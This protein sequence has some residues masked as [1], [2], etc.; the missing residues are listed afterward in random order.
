MKKFIKAIFCFLSFFL[1]FGIILAG[2]VDF[3]QR[4]IEGTR[5]FVENAIRVGIILAFV[6]L[7]F[8]GF[9]FI[10]SAGNVEKI[11]NAR[12]R[13]VSSFVGLILLLGGWI[14][15]RQF[16]P[17]FATLSPARPV[18]IVQ[19]TGEIKPAEASYLAFSEIPI[20]TFLKD[21]DDIK[22]SHFFNVEEL[23]EVKEILDEIKPK[24]EEIKV[25]FEE[26][27]SLLNL[28][29]CS[30]SEPYSSN[31]L[32]CEPPASS[33][34]PCVQDQP[35]C[36]AQK[37][38]GDPCPEEARRNMGLRMTEIANYAEE[39]E[40]YLLELKRKSLPIKERMA[41]L[42]F[43]IDNLKKCPFSE[44]YNRDM[45]SFA[46]DYLRKNAPNTNWV[47]SRIPLFEGI[48]NPRK[49]SIAD[50]YCPITGF[51]YLGTHSEEFGKAT[52]QFF[53]APKDVLSPS[54]W[55]NF[56]KGLP[57]T[58][59][60]WSEI[61]EKTKQATSV[62]PEYELQTSC[63]FS[64]PF[65]EI[66]DKFLAALGD[67]VLK[68]EEVDYNLA[69]ILP[70]I[71]NYYQLTFTCAPERCNPDCRCIGTGSC[72]CVCNCIGL[73]C[74][75]ASLNEQAVII[76]DRIEKIKK[77]IESF[78]F[79]KIEKWIEQWDEI[80]K[81]VRKRETPLTKSEIDKL[82]QKYPQSKEIVAFEIMVSRMHYTISHAMEVEAGWSLPDCMNYKEGSL[83][84]DGKKVE[85][86]EE[87]KCEKIQE[88]KNSFPVL[89]TYECRYLAP[90]WWLAAFFGI[91]TSECNFYNYFACRTMERK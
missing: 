15:L 8:A 21:E 55:V 77:S 51:Y 80:E 57:K 44:A 3:P 37:C 45:F 19:V 22:N 62:S 47:V 76:A 10:T 20:E 38:L 32:W 48:Q 9:T 66:I 33:S 1:A 89:S 68:I 16:R 71:N 41:R 36:K 25:K 50:F 4:L 29:S 91:D 28:C 54:E 75:Y 27:K 63:P 78:E 13:V 67:L 83:S 58:V 35:T 23:K 74:D 11:S 53:G 46:I 86:A 31:R 79:S 42:M 5:N 72:A 39:I 90:G 59:Q 43:G 40:N 60:S 73:A 6:S 18:Q 12:K 70:E 49:N 84:P 14:F 69:E 30:N 7:V 81:E 88:C 26:L 52:A 64:V 24:V 65:G 61:V 34:D 2:N 56:F 17:E 87:C 82:Y 85:N